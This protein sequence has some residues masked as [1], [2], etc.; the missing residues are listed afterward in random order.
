MEIEIRYGPH[1]VGG[2]GGQ[3]GSESPASRTT[4]S[5]LPYFCAP[6]PPDSRPSLC[7]SRLQVNQEDQ[8]PGFNFQTV[9]KLNIL[10]HFLAFALAGVSLVPHESY[11][12]SVF[13]N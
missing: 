8:K 5:R 9:P 6:L 4:F 10:V 12:R 3:G 2:G 13:L 1:K 7:Y 11:Y